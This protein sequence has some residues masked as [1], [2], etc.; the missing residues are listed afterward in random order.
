MPIPIPSDVRTAVEKAE[1]AKRTTPKNTSVDQGLGHVDDY[2]LMAKLAAAKNYNAHQPQR[3]HKPVTPDALAV[4]WF[5]KTVRNWKALVTSL[6]TDG[7][8]YE[9]THN[10][11]KNE[12][13]V[14]AYVKVGHEKVTDNTLQRLL[15]E[16]KAIE[17]A[18]KEA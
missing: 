17:V 2:L 3:G 7:M 14:D 4:V 18:R 10:G 9:V 16:R 13:Y 6:V 1:K 5:N 11:E 8:Y 15:K 12:T